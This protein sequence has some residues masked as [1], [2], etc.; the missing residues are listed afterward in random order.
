MRDP[1]QTLDKFNKP[2]YY[3]LTPKILIAANSLASRL[4]KQELRALSVWH[5]LAATSVLAFPAIALGFAGKPLGLPWFVF[6]AFAG[7]P[8]FLVAAFFLNRALSRR[9][10][11][12][13]GD[14]SVTL[15]ESGVFNT[16]ALGD[17]LHFWTNVRE[18]RE[19][20]DDSGSWFA[21]LLGASFPMYVLPVPYTA[22]S[23]EAEQQTFLDAVK[24][25]IES[26]VPKN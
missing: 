7:V 11:E 21:I 10:V 25:G 24:E 14:C 6:I 22:F 23:N 8:F 1:E 3:R 4:Q 26:S 19:I 13:W 5:G 20:K 17:G 9:M 16:S 15:K 18:I 12:N 2:F